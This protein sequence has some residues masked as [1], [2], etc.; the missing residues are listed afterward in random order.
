[1]TVSVAGTAKCDCALSH[2]LAVPDPRHSTGGED[3]ER[4]L[5]MN[6]AWIV[7]GMAIVGAFAARV[8]WRHGRLESDLGFVS[9]QWLAEHRLSQISDPPR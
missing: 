8:A 4:D 6:F 3:E 9:D 2:R 5:P 1:M 7:I